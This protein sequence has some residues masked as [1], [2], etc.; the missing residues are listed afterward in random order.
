[1]GEKE[2]AIASAWARQR[3]H[4]LHSSSHLKTSERKKK[5]YD[6]KLHCGAV[7]TLGWIYVKVSQEVWEE[8]GGKKKS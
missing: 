5:I 6:L 8:R 2:T 7:E 3:G 1:M 4:L